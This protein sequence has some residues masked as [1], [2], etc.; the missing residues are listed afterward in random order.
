MSKS[1]AVCTSRTFHK[2][3]MM[4]LTP[5]ILKARCKPKIPSLPLI[6]PKPVSQA[7]RTTNWPESYNPFHLEKEEWIDLLPL[8]QFVQSKL[9]NDNFV[10]KL[11]DTPERKKPSNEDPRDEF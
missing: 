6:S 8:P 1:S 5:A 10:D 2:L 9:A 4:F 7:L 11:D 3:I